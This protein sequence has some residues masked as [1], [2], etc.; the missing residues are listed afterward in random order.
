M[1]TFT[2]ALAHRPANQTPEQIIADMQRVLAAFVDKPKME[3]VE[4]TAEEFNQ[5]L[6]FCSSHVHGAEPC[7]VSHLLGVPVV[8]KD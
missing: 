6:K 3:K 2:I 1:A 8:L 5:V 7:T 4:L